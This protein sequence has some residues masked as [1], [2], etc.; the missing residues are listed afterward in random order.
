[1]FETPL[2]VITQAVQR[3]LDCK[4]VRNQN[5]EIVA[6][7][8]ELRFVRTNGFEIEVQRGK[9]IFLRVSFAES[10]SRKVIFHPGYWIETVYLLHQKLVR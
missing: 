3:I 9:E 8:D 10:T 2:T 5:S 1:M 6:W 7:H 4:G